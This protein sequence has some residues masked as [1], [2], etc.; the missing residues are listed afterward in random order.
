MTL[1]SASA[2]GEESECRCEQSKEESEHKVAQRRTEDETL[3]E[4]MMI[5]S[6]N[7]RACGS[8]TN[9]VSG[10][11]APARS[12]ARA[13][14][15]AFAGPPTRLQ[16]AWLMTAAKWQRVVCGPPSGRSG[17]HECAPPP[18]HS[19]APAA[20]MHAVQFSTASPAA[21]A[22]EK[23]GSRSGATWPPKKSECRDSNP[24]PSR[25]RRRFYP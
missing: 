21:D 5:T 10:A 1:K 24:G 6:N 7:T 22:C 25:G 14:A 13:G 19:A 16:A 3:D 18:T 4:L 12:A 2:L 8:D 15:R 20:G 23:A 9:T 11:A 17:V